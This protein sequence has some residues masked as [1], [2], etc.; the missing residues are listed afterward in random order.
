[1]KNTLMKN[2]LVFLVNRINSMTFK[3]AYSQK[4]KSSIQVFIQ[5]LYQN[6]KT[7]TFDEWGVLVKIRIIRHD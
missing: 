1:M 7:S 5:M 4:N 2:N 3:A 6:A